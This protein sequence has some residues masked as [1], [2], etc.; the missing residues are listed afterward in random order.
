MWF[1]PSP[2]GSCQESGA[3][4]NSR[5][6]SIRTTQKGPL[7]YGN[8]QMTEEAEHRLV[9]PA[10]PPKTINLE[11]A[12]EPKGYLTLLM[13]QILYELLYQTL[14]E[15]WT[16]LH[17]YMYIYICIHARSCRMHIIN[18]TSPCRGSLEK[19]I[20]QWP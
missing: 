1:S 12:Q 16:Y 7:I 14:Y 6:L 10:S 19:I 11:P 20:P 4:Q 2:N 15:L 17:R 18:S 9:E 8:P 3:P 13:I 5:A